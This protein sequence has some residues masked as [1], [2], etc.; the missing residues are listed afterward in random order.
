[1]IYA[2]VKTC[3]ESE[4]L[5]KWEEC[6]K[7]NEKHL[8]EIEE[9]AIANGGLLYRF[10][11][12]SVADGRAIYQII[13]VNKNTARVKICQIDGCYNEYIVPQWGHEATVPLEYIQKQINFQ[14]YWR[15]VIK[16]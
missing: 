2:Q 11:Y 7:A 16:K 5:S 4:Y 13:R 14:D 12:E 10:L 9:K 8:E 15:S 3:K 6:I 1:M